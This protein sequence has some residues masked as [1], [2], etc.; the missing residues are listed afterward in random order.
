MGGCCWVLFR[1]PTQR[2]HGPDR[3]H[4]PCDP[5]VGTTPPAIAAVRSAGNGL[6]EPIKRDR[7]RLRD[8]AL[9]ELGINPEKS[10]QARDPLVRRAR[11]VDIFIGLD[12][13]RAVRKD[14]T[15]RAEATIAKLSALAF[16]SNSRST[17]RIRV[18]GSASTQ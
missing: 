13:A 2:E 16:G 18:S 7:D 12:I 11:A 15:D 3:P 4:T 8:K 5:A 14:L 9:T 6:A 17:G 10:S 1:A